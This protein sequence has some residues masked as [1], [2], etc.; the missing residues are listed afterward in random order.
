VALAARYAVPTIYNWRE[1]VAAGGLISYRT[2]LTDAY[3]NAGAYDGKILNG[4]Q[5][6]Y[7]PVQQPTNFELVV[8]LRTAKELNLTIPP[9]ILARAHEVIE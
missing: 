9:S 5:P 7:L 2:S 8:N 3:R 1:Y 4:A 6:A